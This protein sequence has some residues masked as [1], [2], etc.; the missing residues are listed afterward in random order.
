[1]RPHD[2]NRVQL[3]IRFGYDGSRFRGLQP[4]GPGI[5]TAGQALKDRLTEAVGLP[6]KGL[7]FAA[8][9]DAGVHAIANLATCYYREPPLAAEEII[10]RLE[11]PRDDG[12]I[13][14]RAARVPPNVHARGSSRGKRYRYLIEDGAAEGAAQGEHR[15]AW[16]VAP[17]LDVERMREGAQWL[18]G[19]HDYSS[20]RAGDCGAA[21]AT[22]TLATVRIGGPFP[23][24]RDDGAERAGEAPRRIVVEVTGD[25][26]LRKMMRNLVGLLVEVGAGLRPPAEVGAVLAARD[27]RAAGVCA[28][29]GGL[30]LVE[31]GCAWPEDGSG[32]IR[33]L[34]GGGASAPVA[35]DARREKPAG[36]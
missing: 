2:L 16:A 29:P 12:L 23:L 3:L 36:R 31:V 14:V 26:F 35:E 1:M 18:V 4:Q 25:A 10:A 9:T 13:D 30:T 20:L 8:R 33:E 19:T 7:N 15:R 6:P 28:P 27:R 11:A 21:T 17:R 5:A 32:L 34:Q 22:K 24:A